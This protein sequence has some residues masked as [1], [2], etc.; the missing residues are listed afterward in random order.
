M[1]IKEV[2]V[3][4][5]ADELTEKGQILFEILE[6]FED[7]FSSNAI[8]TGAREIDVSSNALYKFFEEEPDWKETV[9]NWQ[10]ESI[11]ELSKQLQDYNS[12]D[13]W[14]VR[15]A[16]AL[17]EEK[18]FKDHEKEKEF[19]EKVDKFADV[20]KLNLSL[21]KKDLQK[22]YNIILEEREK[23]SKYENNRRHF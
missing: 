8:E 21:S 23:Y 15:K 11:D 20:L 16:L 18:K 3:N 17:V 14:K 12:M 10:S 2:L 9:L 22:H 1:N 6:K 5:K 4:V 13:E 7:P 19:H